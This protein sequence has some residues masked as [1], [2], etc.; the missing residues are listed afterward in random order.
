MF[1]GAVPTLPAADIDRARRFYQDVLGLEVGTWEEDGSARVKVGESWIMVYQSQFAG[2][3]QATAVGIAVDD[4]EAAVSTL[5]DRGV[6]FEEYDLGEMKTVDG[7]FTMPGGAK[8]AWFKDTE[9][10]IIGLNDGEI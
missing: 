6:V 4:V 2:T 5:R 9:G 3:N 1:R 8:G 7:I 10:N